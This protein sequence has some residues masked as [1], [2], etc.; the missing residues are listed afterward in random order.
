MVVRTVIVSVMVATATSGKE[1]T[2][3]KEDGQGLN[4]LIKTHGY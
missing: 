1:C 2:Q 4:S 3:S